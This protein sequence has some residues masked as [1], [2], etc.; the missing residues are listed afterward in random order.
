[1]AQDYFHSNVSDNMESLRQIPLFPFQPILIPFLNSSTTK[2]CGIYDSRFSWFLAFAVAVCDLSHYISP[3]D[4]LPEWESLD[5][6]PYILTRWAETRKSSQQ[7]RPQSTSF[8]PSYDFH[9]LTFGG[10][11]TWKRLR[12]WE[13]NTVAALDSRWAFHLFKRKSLS[14]NVSFLATII[15]K[16]RLKIYLDSLPKM[17]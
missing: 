15:P 14:L 6:F 9:W 1:M 3:K 13:R 5:K 4:V 10:K 7:L 12:M 16:N 11:N 2:P 8:T 17:L